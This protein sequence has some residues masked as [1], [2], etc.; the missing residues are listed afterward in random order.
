MI[1]PLTLG[2]FPLIGRSIDLTGVLAILMSIAP[3]EAPAKG[4]RMN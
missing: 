4:G 2:K 3:H 1:V